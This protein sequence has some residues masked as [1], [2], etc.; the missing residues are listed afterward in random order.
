[1]R[2]LTEEWGEGQKR[3][4]LAPRREASSCN[5]VVFFVAAAVLRSRRRGSQGTKE[6]VAS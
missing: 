1:M 4:A 6:G 2:R 5:V 3:K